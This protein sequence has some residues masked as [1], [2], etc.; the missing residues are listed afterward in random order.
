M[1]NSENQNNQ[2][3]DDS[4][5]AETAPATI[6]EMEGKLIDAMERIKVLEDAL[7]ESQKELKKALS[8]SKGSKSVKAVS[9]KD[10][11][12]KAISTLLAG[13]LDKIDRL[14]I[15]AKKVTGGRY[16][17]TTEI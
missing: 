16:K 13:S 2:N 5:D 12:Q 4:T 3:P 10:N 6:E 11:L 9:G 7:A 8:S 17:L 15:R 1:S 14:L